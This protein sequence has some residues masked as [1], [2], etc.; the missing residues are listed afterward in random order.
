MI[1]VASNSSI[2]ISSKFLWLVD[3]NTTFSTQYSLDLKPVRA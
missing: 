1:I 3:I 2:N